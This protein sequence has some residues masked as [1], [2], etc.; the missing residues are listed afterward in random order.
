MEGAY[1]KQA[2]GQQ[3]EIVADIEQP[4]DE[5][6]EEAGHL[7]KLVCKVLCAVFLVG[8]L[9]LIDLLAHFAVDI[10][11][12]VRG[13]KLDLDGGLGS[14]D[15]EASLNSQHDFNVVAGIDTAADDE[16]V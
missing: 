6:D 13:V 16:A 7:G 2:L 4:D 1:I 15:G 10:E 12:S 9:D 8:G 5:A 3:T 11:D 14:A